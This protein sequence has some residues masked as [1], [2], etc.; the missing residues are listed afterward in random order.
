MMEKNRGR[1]QRDI[2]GSMPP[3]YRY[4]GGRDVIPPGDR[5]ESVVAVI[6]LVHVSAPDPTCAHPALLARSTPRGRLLQHA[7]KRPS[8]APWKPSWT[9]ARSS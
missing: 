7:W 4:T 3:E 5:C 8:L 2:N 6:V 1:L 9:L